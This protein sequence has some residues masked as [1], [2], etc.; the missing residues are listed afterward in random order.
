MN[1]GSATNAYGI[2]S[3]FYSDVQNS[4][5]ANVLNMLPKFSQEDYVLSPSLMYQIMDSQV[6]TPQIINNYQDKVDQELEGE[7]S[8]S[9]LLEIM[10]EEAKSNTSKKFQSIQDEIIEDLKKVEEE[11]EVQEDESDLDGLS[12]EESE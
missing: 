11:D 5:S 2:S 8:S 10:E 6:V 12:N 7:G 9:D 1:V 4:N 3:T